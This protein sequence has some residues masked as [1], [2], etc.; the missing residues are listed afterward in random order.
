MTLQ[1]IGPGF[2]R[3]GT[4]STKDALEIL[5]FGPCHH[6]YEVFTNPPQVDAWL[7]VFGEKPVDWRSLFDGY[8]SQID[9]P[10]AHVW[11]DLITA[12]PEARVLLTTRPEESWYRSF[13]KTIG[14]F[15]Q[16]S[17]SLELPPHVRAMADATLP[18]IQK[19]DLCGAGMD[20]K[21]AL[22]AAY[23]QRKAEV[24]AAVDP[25]RLLVFDV[26]EG[27]E[28]LCAF[29]DVPVPDVPFPHENQRDSFW[30]SFGGEPPDPT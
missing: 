12:F 18:A 26:A 15:M 10:G 14:K 13:S 30:A 4:K 17:P 9:W 11:R 16:V 2:G 28:P 20:D 22:L 24:I 6:M 23:R 25:G 19:H 7:E 21:E 8:T 3:T 27:W 1:I 5:G 29:L